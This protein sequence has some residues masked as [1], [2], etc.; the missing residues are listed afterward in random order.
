MLRALT[1]LVLAFSSTFAYGQS[2]DELHRAIGR[3]D[4]GADGFCTGTLV[5]PDM[6]LTAAHCLFDKHTGA[7]FDPKRFTFQIGLINGHARDQKSVSS[8]LVH[9]EYRP[10]AKGHLGNMQHDLA[11]LKL[12][13]PVSVR[14]ALP[15]RLGQPDLSGTSAE[16]L[17][18]GR[19]RSETAT[20]ERECSLK[21]HTQGI[22]VTSCQAALGTS[23]APV[24]QVINGETRL[25]SVVSAKARANGDPVAL[26]VVAAHQ[27]PAMMA[28]V[29]AY[30]LASTTR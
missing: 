18:Y 3:V 5:A 29:S 16:L 6:V 2:S 15:I 11:L 23:G 1:I 22:L 12:A 8:S 7:R 10:T 27:V 13:S 21:A 14:I 28:E 24:L 20:L 26:A 4:L 9:P 17:S 19:G 30:T 25:V